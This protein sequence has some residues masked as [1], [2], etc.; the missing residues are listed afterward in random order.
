[1]GATIQTIATHLS[2][3]VLFVKMDADDNTKFILKQGH[4]KT[5]PTVLVFKR[6]LLLHN[7]SGP[8]TKIVYKN[9][10]KNALANGA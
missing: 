10:I 9:A 2:F 8:N 7:I 3:K 6:Q 5:V 4:A 1:M